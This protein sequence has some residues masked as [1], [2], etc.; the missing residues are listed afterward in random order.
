MK[1]LKHLYHFFPV[2]LLILHFKK[3]QLLLILWLILF[4]SVTSSLGAR[5]GIPYLF[6]D[7]E[8]LGKVNFWSFFLLGFACGGFIMVW[9]IT[10]YILHGFRF[11]FLA[12]TREPFLKYCLNNAIIPVIF[13][14]VYLNYTFVFQRDV[15]FATPY[16]IFLYAQ[17]FLLGLILIIFLSTSYF[18]S[19]NR[20]INFHL[21]RG[22]R[23]A[24]HLPLIFDSNLLEKKISASAKTLPVEYYLAK[25]WKLHH[26]RSVDH[27]PK[28]LLKQIYRQHHLNALM[29]E[30]T[31]ILILVM[32]GALMD[33][34]V[35]RLPSGAAVFLLFAIVTVTLGAFNY[36]LRGWRTIV[37]VIIIILLNTLSRWNFF[38]NNNKVF[39]LD[40]TAVPVSYKPEHLMSLSSIEDVNRDKKKM[41]SI[42]NNWRQKFKTKS[43]NKPFIVFVNVSGGGLRSSL[44]VNTVLASLDSCLQGEFTNHT[45]LMTGASGGTIGA[46]YYRELYYEH[47][48]Q[49]KP[50]LS[51]SAAFSNISS[52]LLNP[53]LS[54][55]VLNDIFYP[56][57]HFNYGNFTYKKDRA[58]AFEQRLNENTNFIIDK[59]IQSYEEPERKGQIPLLI[60][61][62]TIVND[63]HTLLMSPQDLAFMTKPNFN[64]ARLSDSKIDMVEFK[65]LFK[66]H[67]AAQMKLTTALRMNASFPYILP[68]A[69]LPTEPKVAAMDAGV[70]DNYGFETS[71]RFINVFKKWIADNTAGVILVQIT[72]FDR[73]RMEAVRN[74]QSLLDQLMN[75]VTSI[76]SNFPEFQYYNQN[77]MVQ[78]L[79][80][81]FFKEMYLVRFEYTS[82]KNDKRAS[83]SFHLTEREKQNIE[84]AIRLKQNQECIKKI[85]ELLNRKNSVNN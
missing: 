78:L 22:L 52:D 63:G 34:P 11:R 45:F 71:V 20:N 80:S 36:W 85:S 60:V 1:Y 59:T 32:L 37:F 84:A 55:I 7:P 73:S 35:F 15:E 47:Y 6:L 21:G 61:G 3:Q 26:A 68:N 57:H 30:I 23:K 82:G 39:G 44:W 28:E 4:G 19:T 76:Y 67:Q 41:E 14:I 43:N 51:K 27:Y 75:P 49:G 24:R 2:Q 50:S 8:Y 17:G 18:F 16:K 81:S 70:R 33:K 5:F 38:D 69:F 25:P 9:N 65:K 40:Y 46:A 48:I 83:L 62:S 12:A 66:N 53:V 77:N 56:L 54:S 79:S 42:L 29:V 31:A 10:T 13:L 58:Y 74:E 64:A 72:D